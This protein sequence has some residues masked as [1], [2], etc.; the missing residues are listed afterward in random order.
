VGEKGRTGIS[1]REAITFNS[2]D[3]EGSEII[4]SPLIFPSI[5]WRREPS[6][7]DEEHSFVDRYV[8][9]P[10]QFISLPCVWLPQLYQRIGED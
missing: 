2:M 6:V 9:F 1:L 7:R 5:L 10:L 3:V 8:C 4:I